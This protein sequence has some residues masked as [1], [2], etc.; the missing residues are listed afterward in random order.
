MSRVTKAVVS[1]VLVTLW[2]V[3]GI[4]AEESAL[5]NLIDFSRVL[6]L[7]YGDPEPEL[8]EAYDYIVVGAGPAGSVVANRL[9][10]DPEVTVLLLE[11]GKA[12]IPLI[13]QVPGLFVTQ[14]LTDYNFGYLTERQRKACLGLVDQRCAWHQGRGLGGSTI[15]NDMLYTRGNR[16]EFDYWNVTGNPGWSYEEVL[17]YF[18]KSEDA[19]IKDF[20]SNGYHNKGGFL[21]VEDATYRSPLVKALIKSAE[22]VGL[23]YVDYNAYEQTGSSYAQFTLRKGRRMSAGAAFLQPISERKNLHILTRAWVSK[24][25]FEGNSAEGV[26]YMRNKKTYHT[27]AKREVILSGGTFGSAKLLMLSGVG[28]QDHLGELGIKVVRNLPVGETLYD[29]PAVLG[30]VFTAS[31][32]NDGNENSNAFF[33]LP[34]LMQYLQGQGP[35]SSALAEGFAFFRSPFALYPD[36]NWPDVELL[37]LFINPGDDATPAAMKYFRINNETMEKYFKPLYNKRAFMFLSVL[38]HSTTKGSL[39]L[40]STNPFDHP[41]FRYQYFDDDRD[42][43][44]L[45]Y[46]MKTAVKITSQKPFR[47]LGV[48]LYQ[49]KLPGCKHLT[50]NSHEYWRCHAMTLTYVGYHF[51]GT[52]KMGPRSDRTAVVDHRLR[53]HGLRKLRVA[54]VGIIPEAP[55]GHT[56]AYAYMIGEKAADMIKQDNYGQRWR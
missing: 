54:D 52:C 6:G 7:Y 24:V 35:M 56:Q 36:P 30:P 15:I 18:L 28:P 2:S 41:E 13:Q 47:D 17:P 20:G 14:A 38:L 3:T 23:P 19:K 55:S 1:V 34:N 4:S 50:F 22:K 27:K 29:H 26:T 44:A 51:V 39:R 9:T 5:G 32:L 10:E 16:R 31:N 53:V 46:A 11:I 21:P 40:K 48:K 33:S 45:V 42:L 37:Q 43:E 25:L 49:N 12:E 8:L